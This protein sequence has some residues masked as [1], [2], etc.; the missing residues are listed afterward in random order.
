VGNGVVDPAAAV[1]AT[2]RDE[3]PEVGQARA[4]AIGPQAGS[5][6]QSKT[7][8]LIALGGTGVIAAALALGALASGPVK[9]LRGQRR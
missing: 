4:V 3:P 2:L 7:P 6:P 8:A 5:A 1:T 9:R